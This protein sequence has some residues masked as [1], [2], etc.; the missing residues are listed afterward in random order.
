MAAMFIAIPLS[1]M[2]LGVHSGDEVLYGVV[3]GFIAIILFKYISKIVISSFLGTI[4]RDSKQLD[5]GWANWSAFNFHD[6]SNS[7]LR[8][9][10]QI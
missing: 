3:L 2:Y 5:T 10:S 6:N 9:W 4:D 8:L 7:L 1:R